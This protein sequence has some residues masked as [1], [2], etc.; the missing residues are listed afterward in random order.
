MGR[1]LLIGASHGIGLELAKKL[2]DEGHRVVAISRTSGDLPAE[3]DFHACDVC[4]SVLPSLGQTFDGLAYMPGTINLKPFKQISLEEFQTD[5]EINYLGAVKVIK[6]YLPQLKSEPNCSIVL[7]SSVAAR[8][9]M[10][11]HASIGGAKAAIEGLALALAAEL[12]PSIRVNVVAP[13]LT[14]TQLAKQMLNSE[15][16][17]EHAAKRHPLQSLGKPEEIAFLIAYL[18]SAN[19]RWITGQVV[20]IDGGFS[21]LRIL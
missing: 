9:G 5:L 11:Y 7:M 17:R 18:L 15:L 6:H 19:S 12:A 3:V 13:S 4:Q 14:D 20:P 8:L 16:K 10:P 2:L 21:S 1:Y